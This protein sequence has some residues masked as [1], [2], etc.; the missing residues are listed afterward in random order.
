[1]EYKKGEEI[2]RG[3]TK[4]VFRVAGMPEFVILENRDDITAFDDPNY[5]KQFEKKGL[6]IS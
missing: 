3:K 2:S 1:M 6:I 4:S 5:T